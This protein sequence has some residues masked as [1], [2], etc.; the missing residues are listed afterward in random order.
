MDQYFLRREISSHL[1]TYC[2]FHLHTCKCRLGLQDTELRRWEEQYLIYVD[3]KTTYNTNK[4]LRKGLMF[5][6]IIFGNTQGCPESQ[7]P[8][9]Q[10][11]WTTKKQTG[12]KSKSAQVNVACLKMHWLCIEVWAG[13]H[14]QLGGGEL[15]W[16]GKGGMA[17]RLV[18]MH[19]RK[20]ES[21]FLPPDKAFTHHV[22]DKGWLKTML[23]WM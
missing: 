10:T 15:G 14:H 17:G 12:T 5:Y 16:G 23:D 19:Q 9:P 2:Y 21:S 7:D 6:L 3:D 22:M 8:K 1:I 18:V 20:E 11:Q 4:S 13:A